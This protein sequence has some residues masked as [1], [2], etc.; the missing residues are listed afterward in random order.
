[1]MPGLDG[2]EVTRRIK[3]HPAFRQV[4]VIFMTGLTQ[5]EHVVRGLGAG[6]VDYVSKPIAVDELLAR[7]RTA[8]R[9]AL[10]ARGERPVFATGDLE[11]D[12][13][14][15]SVSVRGSIVELSLKEWQLLRFMV[16]HAGVAIPY[17]AI[18]ETVWH[19]DTKRTYLHSYV[20]QLRRKI[21]PDRSGV[22]LIETIVGVGYRLRAADRGP[23]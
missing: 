18:L 1:M 23:R 5:T 20:K 8:L 22:P 13:V 21:E 11:V 10:Q 15:R 17:A 3:A 12:L 14:R 19:P 16:R 6:A 9:H 4:P 7:I 2:F